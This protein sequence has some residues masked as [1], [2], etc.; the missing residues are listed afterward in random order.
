MTS[1]AYNGPVLDPHMHMWSLKGDHYPWLLPTGGFA[2]LAEMDQLRKDYLVEDYLRDAQAQNV[3]GSVHIEALWDAS[4]SPINETRWLE[5]LDKSQGIALRYVA[6]CPFGV[7]ET[8]QIMREQAEFERVVGIRQTIAW[9]P[10]PK[11]SPLPEPGITRDGNWRKGLALA[12]KLGLTIDLLMFPW[13]AQEV[14]EL[15][16][17]YP[18]L[19]IVVNHCASPIERTD[20]DIAEW[21]G[22]IASLAG[23]PN[24]YMK[25]SALGTYDPA[26]SMES[27]DF[28]IKRLVESF[29]PDRAM[30][31]SDYPVGRLQLTFDEIYGFFRASATTYST[32][33]QRS[34]FYETANRVYSIAEDEPR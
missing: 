12:E 27:F 17:L 4:D 25:M 20:R 34:L 7:P 5:G 29:G 28:I 14:V 32:A 30:F 16:H 9:H 21:Q 24:I 6:G 23:C 2:V 13:Q 15:A 1:A 8:E 18:D 11:R 19:T 31:A 10:N 33:E 26:P 22:N 3:V